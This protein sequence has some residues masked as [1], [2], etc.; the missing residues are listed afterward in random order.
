MLERSL[1]WLNLS[2]V[3]AVGAVATDEMASTL[4]FGLA[5]LIAMIVFWV[6][7]FDA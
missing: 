2:A 7:L 5:G 4:A 3:C 1:Q 6:V